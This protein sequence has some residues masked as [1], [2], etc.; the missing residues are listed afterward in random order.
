LNFKIINHDLTV[1]YIARILNLNFSITLRQRQ[2]PKAKL[3]LCLAK[4]HAMK[5]YWGL[6]VQLHA[7]LTSA[8]KGDE[9]SASRPGRLTTGVRAPGNH[10][11]GG[12]VDTRASLDAVA[13]RKNPII[14][15]AG[16]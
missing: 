3:S 13:K 6:E 14:A 16:N 4:H 7:F 10:W 2:K 11:T 1:R 12:W 15:P 9:W 5:T 8:L